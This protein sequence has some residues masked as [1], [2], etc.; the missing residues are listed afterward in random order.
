MREGMMARSRGEARTHTASTGFAPSSSPPATGRAHS[1]AG[2]RRLPVLLAAAASIGLLVAGLALAGGG[3]TSPRAKSAQHSAAAY[4]GIPA[5]L[6]KPT[7][8][9]HRVLHASAAHPALSIEGEGIQVTL[10][11]G[12]TVLATA[13]GP[14]VPE[15]GRFPVPQVTPVTFLVTFA[16]ATRRVPIDRSAFALIDGRGTLHRPSLTGL[17]GGAA[18][19][20]VAPG[21]PVT[22][23]L[24]DIL[25]TG[26]G[27]LIWAP[28]G[29]RPLATWD[30]AVEID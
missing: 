12:A 26:D 4:G 27:G 2:R 11:G 21:H 14:E 15:E 3:G 1:P 16:H 8:Q 23:E 9:V 10:A 13:V 24:H 29:T 28:R 19:A 5:W 30:F 18:P 25:P 6:P 22:V 17:H 7:T 20:Q